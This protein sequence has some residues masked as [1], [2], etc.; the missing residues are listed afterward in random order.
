MVRSAKRITRKDIRQP[1][2]FV[3]L[4]G[5]AYR[6]CFEQYRNTSLGVV[7]FLFAVLLAWWGW[8]LYTENQAVLA[9]Q[10]YSRALALHQSRRYTEALEAFKQ[11][12]NYHSQIYQ[13]LGLL[14]RANIYVTL[15]DNA[16]AFTTAEELLRREKEPVNRQLG[17]I[18]LAHA[19]ENQKRWRE[20]L[21]SFTEA[22]KLQGPLKEEA[23]L[24]K[25]RC[26]IELQNFKE[27][28]N[29]YRQHAST[30]PT[31]ERSTEVSLRIQDLEAKL[32]QSAG[33][34]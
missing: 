19:Q 4:A 32:K 22:E 33:S 15:N 5:Q 21:A 29:A 17:Y 13:R 23:L 9:A 24:G 26:S 34:K 8:G 1:D 18:T 27:A 31:S 12:D 3:T 6:I 7:A 25:A 16:K 2:Q 28:L 30:Y 14:Y 20:A 11:L 10:A